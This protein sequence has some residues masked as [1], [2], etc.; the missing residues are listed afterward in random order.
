MEEY[1][2][3]LSPC[4]GYNVL[5]EITS[6]SVVNMR[7]SLYFSSLDLH[8]A[9]NFVWIREGDEWKTTFREPVLTE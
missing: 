4:I 1:I 8:G 2:R 6:F 5:D 9:Y 3:G 7:E